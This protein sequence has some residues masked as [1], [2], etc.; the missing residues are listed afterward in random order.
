M[1]IQNPN[2]GNHGQQS[3]NECN[4]KSP[5]V[6]S[7]NTDDP[8]GYCETDNSKDGSLKDVPGALDSWI[9]EC[10]TNKKTGH[11][12]HKQCDDMQTG[13][14]VSEACKP[15]RDTIYRY[16]KSIRGCDEAVMDLFR[17]VI[18][19]DED[20][21][22]WPV[23]IVWA[24]QER[25]VAAIL[26]DNVRKD[27]SL[28]VDRIKLP[29]LAIYQSDMQFAQDRFT[30]HRAIDYFRRL[31]PDKKPGFTTKESVHERDTVFGVARGIPIDVTYT[32]YAWTMYLEDMNQILE[33]ILLKFSPIAYISV[34]G[35]QWETI[36]K[37][38]SIANNLEVEPGDQNLRVVKFQFNL[39]AQTYIPQPIVRRKA[40]LKTSVDVHNSLNEEEI[41]EV[42]ARIEET[43]EELQE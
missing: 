29:M 10:K 24:S 5:L 9:D 26:Q 18:V 19:I 14:I 20:G 22:A 34:R 35:V 42:L 2:P 11:G 15:N 30:Y 13:Q 12:Q 6:T 27:E 16:S 40:V 21:K 23:P 4:D 36:V 28:V 17:N 33:Q 41:N 8:S 25:A 39:T 32:L 1:S 3:L 31:R 43:I 38:D 7:L 37:L